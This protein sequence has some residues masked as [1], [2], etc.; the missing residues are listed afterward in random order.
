MLPEKRRKELVELVRCREAFKFSNFAPWDGTTLEHRY[1]AAK[2]IDKEDTVWIL[3]SR[4]AGEAKRRGRQV[5]IIEDWDEIKIAVMAKLIFM[6]FAPNSV[7]G[8]QLIET[9]LEEIVEWNTWHDTFWGR[10]VCEN[11]RG[12]GQNWLGMILMLRRSLLVLKA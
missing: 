2:C 9:G 3:D 8:K 5:K 4:T 6:K 11:H 1:Q 12:E 10:C 7:F